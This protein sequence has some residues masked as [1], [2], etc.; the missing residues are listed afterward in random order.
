MFRGVVSRMPRK[1]LSGQ[2]AAGSNTTWRGL[3]S[4]EIALEDA[5]Q[6]AR[7]PLFKTPPEFTN[8]SFEQN[9]SKF[10]SSGIKFTI[11]FIVFIVLLF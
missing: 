4:L 11:Y 2:V 8:I 5:T 3:R 1:H 9:F 7:D 10:Q 6:T